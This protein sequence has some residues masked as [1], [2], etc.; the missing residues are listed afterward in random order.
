MPGTADENPVMLNITETELMGSG[1][2][3][4]EFKVSA[5]ISRADSQTLIDMMEDAIQ[6]NRKDRKKLEIYLMLKRKLVKQILNQTP[7]DIPVIIRSA[8]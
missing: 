1:K 6:A 4:P 8:V 2:F 7:S 3:T 5:E